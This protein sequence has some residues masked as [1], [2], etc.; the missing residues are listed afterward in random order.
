MP[1]DNL[2]EL[3]QVEPNA[4]LPEIRAAYRRLIFQ[5]HPDRNAGE[6]AQEMTQ[7][8]IR[9]YEVLSDPERRAAYDWRLSGEPGLPPGTADQPQSEPATV[10]ESRAPIARGLSQTA[11]LAATGAV[12]V[13]AAIVIGVLVLTGGGDSDDANQT[14]QVV[15][16]AATPNLTPPIDTGPSGSSGGSTDITPTATPNPT[17]LFESGEAFIRN[18]DF[19]RAIDEFTKAIDLIPG[20]GFGY[21]VRGDS[22]FHH[23]QFDLA[24]RDYDKAIELDPNDKSAYNGRGLA[25]YELGQ[26]QLAIEDFD[27]AIVLDGRFASAFNRRG[28]AYR[29]LGE[30]NLAQLDIDSACSLASQFCSPLLSVVPTATPP[31]ATPGPVP[32]RV[33]GPPG[34]EIFLIVTSTVSIKSMDALRRE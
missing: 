25:N 27:K 9:A 24:I 29:Q 12:G 20:Y 13:A 22:Y 11:K 15:A 5:H 8:L 21:Q 30:S 33:I 28:L 17:F 34:T 19:E 18:G 31:T 26:Y 4:G 1:D 7:R 2:Y 10:S 16:P 14:V 32:P 3:L 6:D 23:A